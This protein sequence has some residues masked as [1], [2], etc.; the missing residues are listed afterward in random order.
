MKLSAIQHLGLVALLLT[1]GISA[2]ADDTTPPAHKKAKHAA[3]PAEQPAEETSAVTT[4]DSHMNW[5]SQEWAFG[6]SSIGLG[7]FAT[8]GAA[9]LALQL[10]H[11][12]TVYGLVAIPSTSPFS[13]FADVRFKHTI[14]GTQ[15]LGFHLGG[16]VGLGSINSTFALMFEGLAGIHMT[17][18]DRVV[19]AFDGGP[20]FSLITTSPNSTS[21][22][23][24][25]TA[26][27]LGASVLYMF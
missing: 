16:G 27:Y 23:M 1:T 5:H 7:P 3:K 20:S 13:I 24:I 8:S 6:Y 19:L 26:P 14:L 22:F 21:N 2:R 17:V 10:N 18:M 25:G 12:D 15:H 11:T 4:S 9:T